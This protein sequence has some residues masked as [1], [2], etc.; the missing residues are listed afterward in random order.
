MR[1]RRMALPILAFALAGIACPAQAAAAAPE[2]ATPS[3]FNGDGYADLAIGAPFEDHEAGAITVLVGSRHGL[4]TNG[5]ER[6]SQATPGVKGT[7]RHYENGSNFGSVLASGD[8]DLDGYADLAVGVRNDRAGGVWWAGAVNVLYGSKHGI[9]VAG[10][11]RLSQANLPGTPEA[12]DGFG[13][14]LTTGD[15]DHDG[16]WDLAVGAP[17]EDDG[18]GTPSGIVQIVYGGA[19]GLSATGSTFLTLAMAGADEP[20]LQFPTSL[21]AGDLDGDGYADLAVGAA[22]TTCTSSSCTGS[23]GDVVAYYGS[24]SGLTAAGSQVWNQDSDGVLDTSESDDRF[25]ETLEIGDFDGDGVGDVAIGVPGERVA[26]G[27]DNFGEGA[28]AVLYG[29]PTGLSADGNQRWDEDSPGVP[30]MPEQVGM[31]G[32]ALASGDFDGDGADDLAIGAPFRDVS[33]AFSAGLVVVLRGSAGDGLTSTGAQRLTQ[34]SA[35]V[36]SK[37]E[38][39]DEFGTALAA[40]D[41]GRSGRDDLAI[42]APGEEVRHVWGAGMVNVLYGR[43]T[44]LSA[45]NAQG[46]SQ[47][48]LGVPGK[49]GQTDAFGSSLTP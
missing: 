21:A 5:S 14:S 31:F 2:A 1:S 41:Y 8:F 49:P 39:D 36:P 29:T 25:G 17:G 26:V 30:G 6:W 45:I 15:F 24:A 44:G 32:A 3:D 7:P 42:G 13:A 43:A 46:W 35:G 47:A 37:P 27:L 12:G 22:D 11:Q 10:N 20:S 38:Q 4:T 16:Y 28:V 48:S 23:G 40:A 34:A 18:P 33:S 19:N 9:K